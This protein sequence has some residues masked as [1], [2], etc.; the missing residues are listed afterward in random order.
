MDNYPVISEGTYKVSVTRL[1]EAI[2]EKK[3]APMVF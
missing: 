1:W 2:T 3:N